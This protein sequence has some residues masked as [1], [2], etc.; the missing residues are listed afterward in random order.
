VRL[1]FGSRSDL[2]QAVQDI[3]EADHEAV[4]AN[5]TWLA[6]LQGRRRKPPKRIFRALCEALQAAWI[7]HVTDRARTLPLVIHR[8]DHSTSWSLRLTRRQALEPGQTI[9]LSSTIRPEQVR[10]AFGDRRVVVYAPTIRQREKRIIVADKSYSLTGLLGKSRQEARGSLFETVKKLVESEHTRTGLP[11]AIIGRSKLINLWNQF[12]LGDKAQ[13]FAMPWNAA[14]REEQAEALRAL[15]IPLGYISGYAG[16]VAGSN[17]FAVEVDDAARVSVER[18]GEPRFVRAL[19]ILGNLIPPLGQLASELRGVYWR[20][21]E[22]YPVEFPGFGTMWA[23][24]DVVVD[25]TPTFRTVPLQVAE[26]GTVMA[27]KNVVGFV[28]PRANELLDASY[29]AEFVQIAGRMRGSIPDP[30]DPTIEPRLWIFAGTAL[31]SEFVFDEVLALEE[32][33]QRLG[34][35]SLKPDADAARPRHR[36]PG[37]SNRTIEDQIFQRWKKRGP[38]AT[39]AWLAAELRRRGTPWSKT[40]ALLLQEVRDL[41]ER[42][43][44]GWHASYE[45]RGIEVIRELNIG[46]GP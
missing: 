17:A 24:R 38:N 39:I 2:A 10:L 8:Q 33:R 32:V 41:V 36:P 15:T 43:G 5:S 4:E 1:L 25:W 35:P 26:V 44:I 23:A 12:M 13:P 28:D 42:S 14:T 3:T 18:G 34:L 9:L 40:G 22:F 27:S 37:S 45:E 20:E 31:G 46:S 6:G 30:I 29:E 16:G 21:E 7:C 11:V 19:I